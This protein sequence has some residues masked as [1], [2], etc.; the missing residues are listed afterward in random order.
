MSNPDPDI[1][2]ILTALNMS[3]TLAIECNSDLCYFYD[4]QTDAIAA[5][6][7]L[8]DRLRSQP[9][10][11]S[12]AIPAKPLTEAEVQAAACPSGT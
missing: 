11:V 8:A 2:T 6:N 1:T 10:Q 4:C 3:R 5:A 12:F 9:Q 7:R